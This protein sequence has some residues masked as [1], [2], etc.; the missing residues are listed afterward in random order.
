MLQTAF[1]ANIEPSPRKQL[2]SGSWPNSVGMVRTGAALF[3]ASSYSALPNGW[4]L[5]AFYQPT[6][7]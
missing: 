5:F 7:G 6:G 4:G 2:S 3:S 1:Y